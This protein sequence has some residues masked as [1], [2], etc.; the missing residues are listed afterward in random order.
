MHEEEQERKTTEAYEKL[1]KNMPSIGFVNRKKRIKAYMQL[2]KIADY[3]I[4]NNEISEDEALFIFSL[5][6][7]KCSNFQKAA[8]MTALTL[9]S[10]GKGVLPPI[11]VKFSLDVRKNLSLPS[12]HHS[13]SD[14]KINS[15]EKDV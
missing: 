5:L 2:S 10:I 15:D 7:R 6:M 8:M 3:M 12:T 11:G 13:V 14:E 9:N 1:L 4:E